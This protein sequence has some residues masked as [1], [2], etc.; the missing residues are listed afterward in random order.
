MT[1]ADSTT[2]VFSDCSRVFLFRPPTVTGNATLLALFATPIPISLALG[3]RYRILGFTTLITVGFTLEV[4]GYIGRPLLHS[5]LDN[6]ADYTIFL[7]GITLGATC[8]CGAMVLIV[9]RTT[10]VF[11]AEHRSWRPVLVLSMLAI[12]SLALEF[13]GCMLST[14]EHAPAAVVTGARVLVTGLTV[15]LLAL[16]TF[17]LCAIL[18]VITL[19]NRRHELDPRLIVTYTTT[20]CKLLLAAITSAT[21]SITLRTVYRLVQIAEGFQSPIAQAER[22]LLIFDATAMLVATIS[23]LFCIPV[24]SLGQIQVEPSTRKL[25]SEPLGPTRQAHSQLL[26]AHSGQ[27]KSL[28]ADKLAINARSPRRVILYRYPPSRGMVNNDDLC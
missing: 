11:M 5:Y 23:L 3:A 16:V 9:P 14:V 26:I 13:A 12:M 28:L 18:F 10:Q 8:I 22:P 15:Q 2:C 17:V 6:R 19:Q 20:R 24:R 21:A 4:A 7:I 1:T 27:I 25:A